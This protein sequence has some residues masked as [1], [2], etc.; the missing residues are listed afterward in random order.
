[1]RIAVNKIFISKELRI[2]IRGMF[3]RSVEMA[4]IVA[5]TGITERVIRRIANENSWIDSRERYWKKLCWH[6]CIKDK[7]LAIVSKESGVRYSTLT[8]I[9]KKYNIPEPKRSAWNKRIT[10]EDVELFKADYAEGKSSREIAYKYGF[11]NCKTVL[12]QLHK[13]GEQ[14]RPARKQ[15]GY[16]ESFFEKVDTHDK[17]YIL[18]LLLTDGYILRDYKGFGIQLTKED[19][20][21]LEKIANLVGCTTHGIQEIDSSNRRVLMPGARDMLRLCIYNEKIA[22]DLKKLGVVRNKSLI[23]RYNDCVPNEFLSS[24]FRGLIDGDGSVGFDSKGYP[25]WMLSSAS[26]WFLKDLSLDIGFNWSIN[27]FGKKYHNLRVLGGREE[28]YRMYRWMYESKGDLY[29]RR[30]YEK[31][32]NIIM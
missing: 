25:F 20:Y 15:T 28:I 8:R 16:D 3:F 31:V 22:N 11:K 23:L 5:Q 19:G 27:H 6:A 21:I 24:F 12:D 10:N 29:L 17:A 14:L 32:Q 18:G 1:M 13:I 7:S 26:E 4:E 9:H 2:K 30:K